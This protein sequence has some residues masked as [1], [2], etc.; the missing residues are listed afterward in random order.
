[1]VG[2]DKCGGKITTVLHIL[3]SFDMGGSQRRVLQIIRDF[4]CGYH[5]FVIALDGCYRAIDSYPDSSYCTFIKDVVVR[6]Y[7]NPN[8]KGGIARFI[9]HFLQSCKNILY[10]R[11]IIRDLSPDILC[12]YNWGSLEWSIAGY[13]SAVKKIIHSEDGFCVNEAATSTLM[14]RCVRYFSM[15]GRNRCLVVISATLAERATREWYIPLYKQRHVSFCID[16]C[17]ATPERLY[18]TKQDGYNKNEVVIGWLGMFR[19]EKNIGRLIR[20]IHKVLTA[21][22]EIRLIIGGTGQESERAIIHDMIQEYAI[23][24]KVDIIGYVSDVSQFMCGI[25]IF[26]ISS[27]TEQTPCVLMEAM[28]AGLPCVSTDVGDVRNILSLENAYYVASPKSED[29]FLQHI[30]CMIDN[31]ELR[32]TLGKANRLAI[33]ARESTCNSYAVYSDLFST[34]S[35]T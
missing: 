24:D 21:G 12:T 23:C 18:S 27:D 14:R 31:Q 34:F 9:N 32:C 1:M 2:A 3:P 17:P 5:H 26:V 35:M 16:V 22:Y 8:V 7:L 19:P 25:D 29:L 13:R 20:V 11:G 33:K 30:I 28:A 4:S 6:K 10:A 15:L